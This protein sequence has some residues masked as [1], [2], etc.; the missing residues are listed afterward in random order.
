MAKITINIPSQHVDRVLTA[1]KEQWKIPQ[2]PNPE[3]PADIS[4]DEYIN[5]YT[6]AEWA[7]KQIE[8]YIRRIV[9]GH[10]KRVARKQAIAGVPSDLIG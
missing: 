5:Q 3:Y 4:A 8:L 1:F 10:E 7:K 2:I 6:D 9:V